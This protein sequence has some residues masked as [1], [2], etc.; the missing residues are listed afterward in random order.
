MPTV[1]N[2]QVSR[3]FTEIAFDEQK[4][5]GAN[6][7]V[8]RAVERG[9]FASGRAH[10]DMF[11]KNESRRFRDSTG[12]AEMR[13]RKMAHLKPLLRLD[14]PHAWLG[15]R[16]NFLTSELRKEGGII[17]TD[18]VSSNGYDPAVRE[19]VEAHSGGLILDCGAG[20]RDIYY[21]NVVNFEIV[22]Y[23]TTDVLGIGEQLPFKDNSFDAVL[24]VA[25]LEHVRD[26]FRCAE[27]IARVLKPGGELF[28]CVP[29]LQPLH[30]YPNHYFNA[31][32]QGLRRLFEDRLDVLSVSVPES[33]HP[34]FSLTW[35]VQSWTD[36]LKGT[37]R[38]QFL[39]MSVKE[40]L[41]AP[42]ALLSAAYCSE[43]SPEK[44]LELAS[45]TVLRATKK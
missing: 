21:E 33:T 35:I 10:F 9:A 44:R 27:E 40:L 22:D 24:S 26:P 17:A 29:F 41:Q 20:R 14:L 15:D 3:F 1:P 32:H 12:V 4:Y 36:G 19:I 31:T 42:S 30:G 28:C 6:P 8:A 5:L 2:I 16:I 13:S 18:N 25:V 34:I 43:L 39:G 37:S 23:D 38:E 7:D 11:G 45:A